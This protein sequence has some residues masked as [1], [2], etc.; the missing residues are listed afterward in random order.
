MTKKANNGRNK[1]SVQWRKSQAKMPLAW[2]RRKVVQAWGT[3]AAQVFLDGTLG[4]VDTQLQ[5]LATDALRAP[6]RIVDAL[7]RR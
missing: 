1:R 5:E 7:M 2:A 3:Y 4:H 6:E